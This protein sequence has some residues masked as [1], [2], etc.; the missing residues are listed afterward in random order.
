MIKAVLLGS[1]GAVSETSE[2]QRQSYN[3]ALREAGLSWNWDQETYKE[4]LVN[5]GGKERL[6]LLSRATATEL[7]TELIDT[8]HTR[9]TD[10]ATQRVRK[11]KPPLRPGVEAV[12]KI[13]AKHKL[14]SGFV[15]TTY[16]PNVD[17]IIDAHKAFFA[18]HPFDVI[19][20]KA[21]VRLG[22]PSPECYQEALRQLK[23]DP[24]E[25][26]AIEDTAA[27]S[28]AAKRAGL[29]VIATPGDFAEGQDFFMADLV[30][31][32]LGDESEVAA[33][34]KALLMS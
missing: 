1:I 24:S 18:E 9:K 17:A 11:E 8:I 15:T 10:L 29:R 13:S 30:I 20:T 14:K 31:P 12:L 27:S 34:V 32:A 21:D 2:I 16:R 4:L 5:V 26:V 19:V 3:V 22:K 33:E 25:A 7:S 28:T 6:S 23:L